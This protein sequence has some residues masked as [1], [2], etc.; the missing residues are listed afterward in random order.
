MFFVSFAILFATTKH[1]YQN[2]C[3][4]DDK[5]AQLFQQIGRPAAE[6]GGASIYA[7]PICFSNGD[8]VAQYKFAKIKSKL[9]KVVMELSI[10]PAKPRLG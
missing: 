3:L 9:K 4:W 7:P 6:G 5:K 10:A 8:I 2:Y 1:Y